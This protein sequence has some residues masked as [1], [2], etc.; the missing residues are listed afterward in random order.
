MVSGS[1]TNMTLGIPHWQA[2]VLE[3]PSQMAG[4]EEAGFGP[5]CVTK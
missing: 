2:I 5:R 3:V 1:F 4:W